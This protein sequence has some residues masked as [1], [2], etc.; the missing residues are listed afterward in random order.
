MHRKGSPL[1][2]VKRKGRGNEWS[3]CPPFWPGE[4]RKKERAIPAYGKKE[5]KKGR[6]KEIREK[7]KRGRTPL[8]RKKDQKKEEETTPRG[9]CSKPG[10]SPR[11]GNERAKKKRKEERDTHLRKS[12]LSSRE[13]RGYRQT[14][15]STRKKKK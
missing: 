7:E 9:G 8:R 6:K 2:T 11:T 15:F 4:K 1:H 13:E 14:S 12:F 3:Y 5:K 10:L